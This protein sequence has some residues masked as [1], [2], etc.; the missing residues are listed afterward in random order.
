MEN[1]LLEF[2]NVVKVKK[3]TVAGTMH[4]ITIRVT[5]GGAKKLYEAKVWEKPWENFKKL[6]E[7]KLVEDVPSA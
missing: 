2:E 5:E 6:E 1:A 4:Y 7:F 3:Q